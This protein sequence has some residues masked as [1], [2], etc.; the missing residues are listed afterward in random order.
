MQRH[1][2]DLIFNEAIACVDVHNEAD[3]FQIGGQGIELIHRL[4]ELFEV[5]QPAR[6]FR[7]LIVAPHLRIARLI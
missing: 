3:M 2:R 6:R 4:D 5:L 7:I 1:E